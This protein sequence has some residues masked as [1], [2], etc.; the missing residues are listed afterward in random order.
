M[1]LKEIGERVRQ[2]R[3]KKGITQT[4]LAKEL[5]VSP[6]FLSNIEQGKQTMSVTTLSAICEALDVSADWLL[7]DGTPESR[8]MT[9]RALEEKLKQ[10][11][12]E[13]RAAMLKL[14]DSLADILGIRD[15]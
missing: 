14:M 7:R 6:H 4:Q 12:P 3:T 8:R 5:E 11:T 10:Y 15:G 13:Q 1:E 9:D 2:A